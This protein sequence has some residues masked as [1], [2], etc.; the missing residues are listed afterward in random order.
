MM[1]VYIERGSRVE[2]FDA[3]APDCFLIFVLRCHCGST[4]QE[5]SYV[6]LQVLLLPFSAAGIMPKAQVAVDLLISSHAA[7]YYGLR[8]SQAEGAHKQAKTRFSG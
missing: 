7:S 1:H 8:C 6:L 2:F 3:T 4:F 5:S